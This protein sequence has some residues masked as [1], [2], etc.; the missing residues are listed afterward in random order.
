MEQNRAEQKAKS[1]PPVPFGDVEQFAAFP[2]QKHQHCHHH[3]WTM[4]IVVSLGQDVVQPS[5][6]RSGVFVP[7]C[8]ITQEMKESDP[9]SQQNQKQPLERQRL[10]CFGEILPKLLKAGTL[11]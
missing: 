10:P 8:R 2:P 11:N 7:K 4:L 3:P 5:K 1:R 6:D 9:K